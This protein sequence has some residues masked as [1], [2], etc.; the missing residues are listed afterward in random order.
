M[1]QGYEW[2]GRRLEVREDHNH[3]EGAPVSFLWSMNGQTMTRNLLPNP[4]VQ[5]ELPKQQQKPPTLPA[6]EQYATT[7][8]TTTTLF[9]KLNGTSSAPNQQRSIP[10][11]PIPTRSICY[12]P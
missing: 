10:Q 2:Q 9:P 6:F 4:L 11:T 3:V 7:T 5:P 12:S 1:Y 8:T